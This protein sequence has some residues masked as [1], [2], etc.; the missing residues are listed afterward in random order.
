VLAGLAGCADQAVDLAGTALA[1][2][3]L[4]RPAARIEDYFPHID[5][6]AAGL[7]ED[8]A[9]ES[10]ADTLAAALGAV[11]ARRHFYRSDDRDDDEVANTSLMWVIDNRRGSA[12]ALGILALAAARRAGWRAEGLA[13]PTHFLLR[14]EDATGRR[15]ILDPFRAWQ[16]VDPASMRALLKAAAGLD[17]ELAPCHYAALDNRAILVRLQN[18]AK[19]RLLR[20]GCIAR[21][22][23]VVEATL[24]F[25]PGHTLLWREA[26]L[27]HMRLDQ[28]PAAVA[29]LEQFVARTGNP[30]A[31][32]RTNELLHHLRGRL[33]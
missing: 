27:M 32:R 1:L 2:A 3:A 29:A 24:L 10:D 22:L 11:M 14:I 7:A 20:C 26:G 15:A 21:A 30:Q 16:V 12:E 4:D 28:L 23:A 8:A 5:T 17:A 6:L 33:S 9:A 18:A 31:R 25:A 19:T 13:F